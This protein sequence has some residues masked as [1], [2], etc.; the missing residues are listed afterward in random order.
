MTEYV[1]EQQERSRVLGERFFLNE[2]SACQERSNSV[3][4]EAPGIDTASRQAQLYNIQVNS[5]EQLESSKPVIELPQKGNAQNLTTY[6]AQ[7]KGNQIKGNTGSISPAQFAHSSRKSR[8]TRRSSTKPGQTR[9]EYGGGSSVNQQG[10]PHGQS[11]GKAEA[12]PRVRKR[13]IVPHTLQQPLNVKQS[14]S[15]ISKQKS[16]GVTQIN[17]AP[18]AAGLNSSSVNN[19]NESFS[20]P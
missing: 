11:Q 2:N 17:D 19:F 10:H 7:I 16:K 9:D 3:G 13:N 18:S 20:Y 8:S 15:K 12:A 4:A 1:K 5:E 6:V 14:E